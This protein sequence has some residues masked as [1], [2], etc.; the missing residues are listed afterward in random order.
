MLD[1][2]LEDFCVGCILFLPFGGD[3]KYSGLIYGIFSSLLNV[4]LP[5]FTAHNATSIS[6]TYLLF[7]FLGIGLVLTHL[8]KSLISKPFASKNL[9]ISP[10]FFQS[11]NIIN[12]PPFFKI[13]STFSNHLN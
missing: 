12:E 6:D 13:L 3:P 9:A 10:I 5:F 8:I 2:T 11:L 4:H 1:M 7:V